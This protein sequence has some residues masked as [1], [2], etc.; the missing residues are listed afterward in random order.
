MR[1]LF[2]RLAEIIKAEG[3]AALD[4]VE[5]PEKM[6]A[7]KV[8]NDVR[9]LQNFKA[10]AAGVLADLAAAKRKIEENE[11]EQNRLKGF[12][13][14]ALTEGNEKEARLILTRVARLAVE[15]QELDENYAMLQEA[16]DKVIDLHDKFAADVDKDRS[17]YEAI[18]AKS[19]F[20]NTVETVNR[21]ED[22][23][24][25]KNITGDDMSKYDS[26]VNR[27]LDTALAMNEI[28]ERS[29]SFVDRIISSYENY[30]SLEAD[31]LLEEM[32]EDINEGL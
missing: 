19:H 22:R 13:K 12:A 7:Q 28:N 6:A 24:S 10:E 11:K 32:K 14:K 31:A 2:G 16:S 15:K 3:N 9:D 17:S 25:V 4:K 30:Y 8:R 29:Y 5:N 1:T 21:A 27:R 26:A 18:R 20:A 23:R